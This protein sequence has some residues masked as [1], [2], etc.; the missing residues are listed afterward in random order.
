MVGA[1]TSH[2]NVMTPRP[3]DARKGREISLTAALRDLNKLNAFVR[4]AERGSFTRAAADLRTTPSVISKHMK[5]L[6]AALGFSLFNRSTHGLML[7]DAGEGLFQNSLEMLA[8]LDNYVVETRNLQ[9]APYGTLRIQATSDYAEY[10]L[11]PLLPEFVRRS[12]GLRVHLFAAPED[13]DFSAEGFDVIVA[14]RKPALPGLADRDLGSIRHVVCASP[15]YFQRFGRP[16]KPQDLREHNC[17]VH[18]NSATKGWPFQNGGR[19]THVEVKGTLSASS[20][21][22]LIAMALE[23]HGIVRVP[24]FA[25]KARLADKSLQA[26]FE[27]VTLSPE[28]MRAYSSKARHVPAKT[29]EFIEFLQASVASR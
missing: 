6:E 29:T 23:G 2:E 17:L 14:S 26:A 20:A 25:V 22:A 28:R 13:Y 10:V 24:H 3:H 19:Q 11:A 21:G 16:T 12:Q 27:G 9:K 4:V 5:E 15:K 8:K 18:L 1:A 7:T